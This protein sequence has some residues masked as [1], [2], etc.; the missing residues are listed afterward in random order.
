MRKILHLDLDAFFCAVE[1]L[2]RPELAGKPFAV[3]GRPESRGVIS[4]C[5][6][7]A[8]A[9]GIRSAMPTSRA[10]KLCPELILLSGRHRDY[11]T[12][13]RQVMDILGQYTPLLEQ[14]SIDEAFLDLSDLPATGET[15]AR[16]LQAR[17]DREVHLPCSLGV[18]TNK[19]VAKMATDEGK[20]RHKGPSSPRSILVVEPGSERAFLAP[21]RIDAL[22]GIGPKSAERL[23][24]LGI[25][26]I[27]DLANL[28][29][30][31]LVRLFGKYGHELWLHA[32]GID[33][34][35]VET[36]HAVKSI[37]QET[38]FE[39]DISDRDTLLRTL[40][41]LAEQ[42]AF[43]LRA[44]R[45]VA[46]TVRIKVRWPDFSLQS[47]QVSLKQPTDLDREV[48]RTALDLFE[49]FWDGEQPV[50]L[51]GVGVSG[52]SPRAHQLSLL[53]D[54]QPTE[55]ERSLM[56]AIDRLRARYGD[57][58]VRRGAVLRPKRT[59]RH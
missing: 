45:M 22:W 44:E 32:Q 50:R 10:F 21:L 36:E 1:E 31:S 6:Y 13:S 7:A 43:R 48:A 58:I 27:G 2:K 38:T 15:L 18:A 34:R 23:N 40:R 46:S 55:R 25:R 57:E 54:D 9:F 33:D 29:E 28:G 26:T 42:V 53:E 30:A 12:V 3:G 14:V 35:P 49:R 41:E 20:R 4:S 56:D 19:L 51:I 8:R 5:S 24:G 16:E 37:S 17:I 52:L 47:R 59:D 11:S 39:R